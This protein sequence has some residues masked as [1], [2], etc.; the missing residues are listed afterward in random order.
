MLLYVNGDSHA[1]GHGI[2]TKA[3][4]ACDDP[5]FGHLGTLPHPHNE[6]LSFGAQLCKITGWQRVNQSQ[7]GGSNPRIIRT[8]RDWIQRNLHKRDQ[9]FVLIQWSTWEREEWLHDGVWYQVN[10]SGQDH[11]PPELGDRY[12]Q[13]VL[14]VDW[15]AANLRAHDQIWN[16]HKE[17]E[18]LEIPHLFFNGNSH[19]GNTHEVDGDIVPIIPQNQRPNWNSCYIGPYSRKTT[20]DQILRHEQFATVEPAPGYHFGQDAHCFWAQYLLQYI[21]DNQLLRHHALSPD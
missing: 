20:Y 19:F 14:D 17:L 21:L 13:F 15:T 5:D 4:W 9:I 8:T 6:A 12:K 11:V 2:I 3:G 18:Q 7:S 16:F 1:A 10:A